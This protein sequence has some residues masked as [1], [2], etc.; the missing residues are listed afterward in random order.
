MRQLIR[1]E[2]QFGYSVDQLRE[3]MRK[4]FA[5]QPFELEDSAE[6]LYDWVFATAAIR[7]TGQQLQAIRDNH[8]ELESKW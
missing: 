4:G 1:W 5:S 7:L 2:E 8:P 6:K 3:E